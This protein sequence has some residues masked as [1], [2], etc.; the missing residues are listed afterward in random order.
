L[1]EERFVLLG[2]AFNEIAVGVFAA[3]PLDGVATKPPLQAGPAGWPFNVSVPLVKLPFTPARETVVVHVS[4]VPAALIVH[5]AGTV[6]E[7]CA[8]PSEDSAKLTKAPARQAT[9][10]VNAVNI[11]I[12]FMS[13]PTISNPVWIVALTHQQGDSADDRAFVSDKKKRAFRPALISLGEPSS[14]H[15][16]CAITAFGVKLML[17]LKFNW[18]DEL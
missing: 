13:P 18:Y 6:P 5:V 8:K 2:Q 3:I 12:L 10:E 15:N 16:Y 17:R 7:L 4:E 1:S 11:K 14:L 9:R